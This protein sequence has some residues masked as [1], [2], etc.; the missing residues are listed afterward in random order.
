MI[1]SLPR[2]APLRVADQSLA[3]ILFTSGSSGEPKGVMLSDGNVL[4]NNTTLAGHVRVGHHS[5]LPCPTRAASFSRLISACSIM[6]RSRR[7][8]LTGSGTW[9]SAC[10]MGV[11]SSRE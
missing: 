4:A 10:P 7:S 11:S 2:I 5:V 3:L 8:S 1:S 9:S 6:K